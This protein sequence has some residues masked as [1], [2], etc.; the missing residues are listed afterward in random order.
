MPLADRV[1]L[2][3]GATGSLG[4]ALVTAFAGEG[5][6]LGL[7]GTDADRLTALAT[8]LGLDASRWAPGVGDLTRPDEARSAI[9]AVESRF[10]QVDAL[11][12]AVGGFAGGTPV[13]D[14][15]RAEMTE[16][17][18]QH[19]WT[20]LHA[21]QA[22]LPGMVERGWGRI[23]AVTTAV[24]TTPVAKM[25]PY[26]VGKAAEETLLRVV[27]KEVAGTGVTVNLV[28]VKKIDAEHEREKAPSSKNASWTTPEEIA[29]VMRQLCS[30]DAAP[31]NGA[32]IPL[33]GR[34]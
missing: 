17:L 5:C 27:A 13:A 3:T 6:R 7:V 31:V 33:D 26:A 20:T 9:D 30:D 11:L 32:R 4:R 14:L 15:D 12:H 16:M 29:A 19:L 28:S 24:A 8:E 21:V 1:V 2:I 25:A 34:G 23:V 22:V 10:G 18:D